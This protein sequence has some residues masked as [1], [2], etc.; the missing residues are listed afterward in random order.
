LIPILNL[1]R[2]QSFIPLTNLLHPYF[3]HHI[4]LPLGLHWVFFGFAFGFTFGFALYHRRILL[5]TLPSLE[6]SYLCIAVAVS[7]GWRTKPFAHGR[8]RVCESNTQ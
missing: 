2:I 3:Y 7:H 5:D 1:Q 6:R 8:A 4:E